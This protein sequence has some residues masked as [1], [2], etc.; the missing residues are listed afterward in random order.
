MR[1]PRTIV[2]TPD[3]PA[4][5]APQAVSRAAAP[6]SAGVD[7]LLA[8]LG[9][10]APRRASL[11]TMLFEQLRA[12]LPSGGQGCIIERAALPDKLALPDGGW[13]VRYDFRLPARGLGAAPYTALVTAAGGATQ[14][15]SG[16]VW[17]DREAEGLQVNRVI[18]RGEILP[19]DGVIALP[20]RL[21]Q[22]PRGALSRIADVGGTTAKSEIRP[23]QWLTDQM[24]E[25]ATLVR[26]NQAVTMRVERGPIRITAPGIAE[27][28]GAMG[29]V[30][31]VSNAQSKRTIFARVLSKD[32]VQVID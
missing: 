31:R 22:L 26:R 11:E 20:A 30:I 17:I 6:T 19:T 5:E 23:G 29:A 16:S 13:S 4:G 24:V 2:A 7:D 18:R 25:S 28:D 12:A 27:Q 8:T 15:F 21:S 32:E 10:E 3:A 14:R 1:I 9:S